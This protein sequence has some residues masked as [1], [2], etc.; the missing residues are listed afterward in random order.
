MN[1]QAQT[2]C[3]RCNSALAPGAQFC[4]A[5]G[6]PLGVAPQ[7][8]HQPAYAPP[9]PMP[10]MPSMA[11]MARGFSGGGG[12]NSKQVNLNAA[13]MDAFNTAMGVIEGMGSEV[14]YRQ[15]PQGAK[16]LL[17][18]KS[19]W[20]TLGI[21]IKY[22]GDMQVAPSGPGQSVVR[23][24]LKVRWG[25]ALPLFLVQ[26]ATTFFASMFNLYFAVYFFF[27]LALYL[28]ITAWAVSSS[29][30][31]KALKEMGDK[32]A[33]GGGFAPAPAQ[34]A[35]APQ[36]PPA[37]GAAP[38]PQAPPQP[39]PQPAYAAPPMA[40]APTPQ[41]APGLSGGSDTAR[42]MEQIKQLGALRDA[43]ILSAAEFDAKKAELLARI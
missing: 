9:P 41:G 7:P 31:E 32:M 12:G 14:H 38:A 34:Y 3:P 6:S 35:P 5:C 37:Y 11:N 42:I 17:T 16:Y 1:A 19:M 20:S 24:S 36:H 23:L 2:A 28:G 25:S 29:L 22:D 26:A 4:G 33:Q 10:Q 15:P 39:A 40:P 30:P 8:P 43:G 18:Y 27:I 21:P 13:P